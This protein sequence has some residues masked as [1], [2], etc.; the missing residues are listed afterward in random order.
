M[1]GWIDRS[2][3]VESLMVSGRIQCYFSFSK[4]AINQLRLQ[5]RMPVFYPKLQ[6][7]LLSNARVP[8]CRKIKIC[9]SFTALHLVTH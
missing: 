9:H 7:E 3:H 4:L 5:F 1:Y 8:C 6:L 2:N